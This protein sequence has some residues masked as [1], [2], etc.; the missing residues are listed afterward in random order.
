VSYAPTSLQA[1]ENI[2]VSDHEK[3]IGTV[4]LEPFANRARK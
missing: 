1:G 2:V 3:L 4:L